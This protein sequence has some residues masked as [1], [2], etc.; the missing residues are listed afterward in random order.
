MADNP[1]A[2][3]SFSELRDHQALLNHEIFR[4]EFL[5]SA[6]EVIRSNIERYVE[7]GGDLKDVRAILDSFS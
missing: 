4:R 7:F 6:P 1:L 5:T 2:E 3:L